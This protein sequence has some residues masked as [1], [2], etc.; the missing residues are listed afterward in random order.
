MSTAA[1]DPKTV[2]K[3]RQKTFH[4]G[5]PSAAQLLGQH[6]KPVGR[7]SLQ[8][9]YHMPSKAELCEVHLSEQRPQKRRWTGEP[10]ISARMHRV[11]PVCQVLRP[12]NL[13]H[14]GRCL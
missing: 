11:I 2:M 3:L 1:I 4:P 12:S 6:L 10:V 8:H 9:V 5:H 14:T 13:H 7:M